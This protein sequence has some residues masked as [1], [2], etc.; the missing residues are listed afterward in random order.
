VSIEQLLATKNKLMQVLMENIVHRGGHQP[1]LDSFYIVFLATHPLTLI[2][3]SD[4]LEVD[5]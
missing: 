1:V 2:E 3:V 5:N 4:P